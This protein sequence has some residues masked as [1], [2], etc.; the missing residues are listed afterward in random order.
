[1][2][3]AMN[4]TF[5]PAPVKPSDRAVATLEL[6]ETV[7]VSARPSGAR[8]LEPFGAQAP[9]TLF[10]AFETVRSGVMEAAGVVVVAGEADKPSADAGRVTVA[11][12][13]T[14]ATAGL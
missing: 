9:A 1:M 3:S 11:S 14:S 10:S 13:I 6:C 5:T 8:E 2:P 7:L 12:G 4:A